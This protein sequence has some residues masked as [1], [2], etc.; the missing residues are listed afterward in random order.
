MIEVFKIIKG[1]IL[2][3]VKITQGFFPLSSETRTRGNDLKI[4]NRKV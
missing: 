3:D 4:E 1:I 2:Y